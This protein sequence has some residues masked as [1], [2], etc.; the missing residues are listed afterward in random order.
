MDLAVGVPAVRGGRVAL[1]ASACEPANPA[2]R[3]F[4]GGRPEPAAVAAAAPAARILT[5]A[6]TNSP[7]AGTVF[8]STNPVRLA[9]SATRSKTIGQLAGDRHAILLENALI[10]TGSPLNFSIPKHL[11]SPGDPGAYIV[12]ARGPIDAAFRAMLAAAGAEIVSYIPNDAYLVRAPAGVA[13]GL[14]A[15]PLTQAVIP[16]EPYYKIQ[17]SL[18][19]PAMGQMQLPD[20]ASLNLGLFPN[21]APTT[22]AQIE[23]LGGKIVS[24]D[25]LAVRPGGAGDPAEEL[26]GAGDAAG[27]ADCR[28]VSPAHPRQRPEPGGDGRDGRH[29]GDHELHESDR[30]E[31]DCGSERFGH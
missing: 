21:A 18:L 30:L 25:E 14:A 12:Q 13:N 15:N 17:S 22:I 9:A 26:D 19:T 4:P 11:R 8:A 1:L 2:V 3:I 5:P 20:G 29:A 24:Q 16:Y 10:D 7:K 27:R 6:Y 23:K 31:C 28:G